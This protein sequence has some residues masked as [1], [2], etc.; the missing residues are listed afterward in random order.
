MIKNSL[1]INSTMNDATEFL[2]NYYV[3]IKPQ[4]NA[5]HSVHREGCP[6]MPADNKRIY[7]GA[8]QSGKEAGEEGKKLFCNSNCCRFCSGKT[9]AEGTIQFS[10]TGSTFLPT[11]NSV[12]FIALLN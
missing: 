8:F 1:L 4:T 10:M 9:S 2:E 12:R 7:L 11:Q 3:A 6:F 5:V